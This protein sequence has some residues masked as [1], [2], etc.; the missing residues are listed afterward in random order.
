MAR[1]AS[2]LVTI[3]LLLAGGGSALAE[4]PGSTRPARAVTAWPASR[5]ILFGARW[6]APC[7]AE[8]A[9]LGSLVAAAQP[10]ALVLAWIDRPVRPVLFAKAAETLPPEQAADLA[11]RVSARGYG[12]PLAVMTDAAGKPCAVRR[13]RLRPADVTAMRTH[14][15]FDPV[16]P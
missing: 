7:M 13:A 16:T 15:G 4:T 3:A 1:I 2:G 10:Q 12:L 9:E 14:C 11:E 5:L 6:C 8:L